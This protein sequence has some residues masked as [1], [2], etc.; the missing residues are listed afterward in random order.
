[1]DNLYGLIG[2][3]L[4]HSFSPAVHSIIMKKMGMGGFYHLFEIKK[5][6]LG[7]VCEALKYMD[8]KGLN[9]TIPYKVEVMKYLN[10]ISPEAKRLNAVNTISFRN[11]KAYGFNTDYFGFGMMLDKFNINLPGKKAAVLG[12]GGAANSVV[13]YLADHGI[14]DI[15]IVSRDIAT[16]QSKFKGFKVC[17]YEEL[18]GIKGFDIIINCTPCGMYPNV[19][20]C[21][22][23]SGSLRGFSY[24]V[25]LIYNPIETLFLKNVRDM[26]LAAVNGLY[27]LIAQ[28][29]KAQEIW[30]GIE[31]SKS[32]LDEVYAEVSHMI[33]SGGGVK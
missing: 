16:A 19:D 30:N 24:A 21:P 1:M 33:N 2:E 3:K 9:V 4:G 18:Q 15:I 14:A 32:T 27:M 25:D 22:V 10:E 28:A 17:G 13:Q 26:G 11:E 23:N 7:T 12:T 20:T 8:I 5:E 31:I 29:V 6:R